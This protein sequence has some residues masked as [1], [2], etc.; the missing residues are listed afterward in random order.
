[1]IANDK[2]YGE[3]IK[4]GRGSGAGKG[5]RDFKYGSWRRSLEKADKWL[6][7][8]TLDLNP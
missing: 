1:M 2:S 7:Q 3:K 8:K 4:E 5:G 6:L